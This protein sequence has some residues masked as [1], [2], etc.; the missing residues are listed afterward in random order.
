MNG[1]FPG[2]PAG[3]LEDFVP[4][5]P[6][7]NGRAMLLAPPRAELTGP[8]QIEGM[9]QM[10]PFPPGFLNGAM[11]PGAVGQTTAPVAP[12]N[13][14]PLSMQMAQLDRLQAYPG[15]PALGALVPPIPPGPRAVV[16]A[17]QQS[18]RPA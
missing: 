15:P 2:M 13:P 18:G 8:P 12:F 14:L 17:E 7:P 4:V 16:I 5:R 10:P 1:P 11:V 9:P 3:G 6:L